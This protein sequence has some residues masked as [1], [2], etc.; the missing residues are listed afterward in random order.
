MLLQDHRE[1]SR[2]VPYL[3]I[4]QEMT[5]IYLFSVVFLQPTNR[6]FSWYYKQNKLESKKSLCYYL[7]IKILVDSYILFHFRPFFSFYLP[8][9]FYKWLLNWNK[10][11]PVS[12]THIHN[13]AYLSSSIEKL[14]INYGF[15]DLYWMLTV[16]CTVIYLY[17]IY[18]QF[19]VQQLFLKRLLNRFADERK[20]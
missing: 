10:F 15:H 8:S 20:R 19:T 17:I 4:F 7:F 5:H 12:L 3:A 11:C 14:Q 13:T 1:F 9:L 18:V 2:N 6:H 16:N